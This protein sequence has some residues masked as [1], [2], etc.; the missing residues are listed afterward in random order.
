MALA[1]FPLAGLVSLPHWVDA[2]IRKR[3]PPPEEL[4]RNYAE[5]ERGSLLSE[6][7]FFVVVW[8]KRVTPEYA[9]P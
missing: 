4:L 1:P 9:L 2:R 5:E 3:P 7:S 8:S 6:L